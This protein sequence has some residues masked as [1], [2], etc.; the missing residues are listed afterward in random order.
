M[1]TIVVTGTDT[2]VGKTVVTAALAAAYAGRGRSV[3]VVK[4]AQTGVTA[5]QAGD[6]DEVRRLAGPVTTV[7]PVR[8]PDPL[9]PDLAAR[10]ASKHCPDDPPRW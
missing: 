7:E 6:L 5:Q 2:D 4:P 8:L 9:A 10:V 1:T 3:C